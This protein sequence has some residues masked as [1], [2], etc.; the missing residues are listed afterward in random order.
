MIVVAFAGL[1]RGG[2]TTSAQMLRDWCN[3]HGMDARICSFAELMKK[4]A[5][6]IGLSK[7]TD[8]TLYRSTLQRWGENKR[9]PK[10]QPGRSGPDYWVNKSMALLMKH[11]AE[12]RLL[13]ERIDRLDLNN[14]F[15]E[16]VIIFDD[17]RY[18]NELEAIKSIGGSTV[19]VDGLS[20]ITD[21]LADWRQHESEAM[22]VMY[23]F[24]A[25]PDETFDYYITN[26][27]SEENLKELINIL[28]PMWLDMEIMA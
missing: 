1:A 23:T 4:A 26:N 20:R 9:N 27:S 13:Y 25:L 24:G 5:V 7:E 12:E 8:P 3:Q 18:P 21:I 16:R 17:M 10:Y 14:E 11:A 28:A 6:R 2:K 22:S 19:F 15:K